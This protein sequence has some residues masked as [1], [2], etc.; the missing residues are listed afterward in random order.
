MRN[1]ELLLVRECVIPRERTFMS[2]DRGNPL[3]IDDVMLRKGIATSGSVALLAMT[4]LTTDHYIRVRAQ[5]SLRREG[6]PLAVGGF[7]KCLY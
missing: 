2:G 6:G 7:I 3:V 1:E 4:L 5:P